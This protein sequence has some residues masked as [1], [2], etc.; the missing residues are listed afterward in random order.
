MP[1]KISFIAYAARPEIL[2][3]TITTA[4]RA[5]TEANCGIKFVP[6]PENDIAGRP[7]TD[8]ILEKIGES[9][10]VVADISVPNFNVFYEIGFAIGQRK[11]AFLIRNKAV[12]FND[13]LMRR[14]GIFDVLGHVTYENSADLAQTLTSI[15]DFAPLSVPI[16]LDARVRTWILQ[17]PHRSEHMTRI[18]AGVKKGLYLYRSFDPSEQARLPLA[19]TLEQI[20][21][22]TGV[23]VPLL[24]PGMDDAEVHNLR[25]AFVAGLAQG[26]GKITL[27]LQDRDV[28]VPADVRD[29][30]KR[31]KYP[32]DI[33]QLIHQFRDD[34]DAA[35]YAHEDNRI[36]GGALERLRLGAPTA[37]N[38]FQTLASYYLRTDEFGRAIRGEANLVIGRKG[39][40]KTALFS[41]VRNDLRRNKANVIVDLKPEGY[42]LLKLKDVVLKYLEPG[43]KAHLV[44]AFWDYV[45]LLE[46][47]YKLLEKDQAIFNR[48]PTLNAAYLTL[49]NI[50][51]S[52]GYTGEGDFSERLVQFSNHLGGS[53]QAAFGEAQQTRLS[54]DQITQV[55]YRHDIRK[56]REAVSQYLN[57]KEQIWVLFD[58]IDKGWS[59]QGVS[60]E[61]I[62]IMHS[63]IEACWKIERDM[64][65][66]GNVF[67]SIIFLRNDVYQMLITSIPDRGKDIR[68]SLDWSDPSILKEV[69]RRRLVYNGMSKELPFNDLWRE[70]VVPEVYGEDSADFLIRRC[71]MRPRYLLL[72]INHCRGFAVNFGHARVLQEDIEKGIM[73]YSNDLIVDTDN[74]LK[75]V[76][77]Q[78]ESLVYQFIGEEADLL[79]E[80]LKR[81]YVRAKIA[82]DAYDKATDFLLWYGFL[83]VVRSVKH[84]S[85]VYDVEVGYDIRKLKILRDKEGGA[86]P[87]YRI[88]PAYWPG[89]AIKPPT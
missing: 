18:V 50:Y 78:A 74:E 6:W 53:Y 5:A 73:A 30:V 86:L 62:I 63:L 44:T 58:N 46:I 84:A 17:T 69:I 35:F 26:L 16:Q 14:I 52:N 32:Q 11:R 29:F 39:S 15:V 27:I 43:S 56:L 28:F 85:F 54:T 22:S 37:E 20:G 24:A 48:D 72:L 60:A 55:L 80:D 79:G 21:I 9:E 76:F 23:V 47:A 59:T 57:L 45:L 40:G 31:Y 65:R 8:P 1:T 61:D 70:I 77:P 10:F 88:N 66:A 89:L 7:L 12:A 87:V 36:T 82:T 83:G 64:R 3:T 49:S 34:I 67:H 41:Q 51:Q 13:E 25:A 38:E 4:A 2:N 71:L 33:D 19:E 81:H 42:Q 68:V 75:D